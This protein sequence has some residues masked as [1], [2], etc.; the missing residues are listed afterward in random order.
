MPVLRFDPLPQLA[1]GASESLGYFV[2]RDLLGQD[3]GPIEALWES[4]GARAICR[5]QQADGSD[6]LWPTGYGRG[7]RFHKER[8]WIGLA[9][10]RLFRRWVGPVTAQQRLVD[11]LGTV[12]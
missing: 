10:L 5:R 9:V 7:P 6:G 1:A 4:P 2:R 8:R 3:P 12:S 11:T